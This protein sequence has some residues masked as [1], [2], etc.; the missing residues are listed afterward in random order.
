MAFDQARGRIVLLVNGQ[1]TWEWDGTDWSQRLPNTRPPSRCYA[2]LA[3][4]AS[5]SR[6][7]LFG[8][9]AG[10][11]F[12]Q[13]TWEWDGGD[14]LLRA[15][16]GAPGPRVPLG[17]VYD[18]AHARTVLFGGFDGKLTL[19]D[20]W[21]YGPV[22]PASHTPF[23]AGC[24]GSAG[25]PA[26]DAAP[27][28]LPWLG[29]LFTLRVENLPPG[30]PGLLWLGTSRSA[31]GALTLPLDLTPL[32]MNGCA[33]R[34]SGD[35]AFPFFSLT[36]SAAVPLSIPVD[37]SLLGRLFFTQALVVDPGANAFGATTSNG[38]EGA[39]GGR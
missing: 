30:N 39:I 29:D 23:G 5:R 26:L 31:W 4:D 18:R 24:A 10:Q 34:V 15:A 17:V 28:Q 14:W 8:G 20:T 11:T 12:L 1:D 37:A 19:G 27:G 21:T 7:V 6:V 35:F 33:L 38:G 3:Y 25:V 16:A 32:G 9:Q 2:S 22:S 13:D 36:G